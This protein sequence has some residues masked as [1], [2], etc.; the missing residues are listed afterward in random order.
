MRFMMMVKKAGVVVDLSGWQPSSR[1]F[2]VKFPGGKRS[3]VD[4]PFSESKELIAGYG[5]RFQL[6]TTT[7]KARSKFGSLPGATAV[8]RNQQTR[9]ASCA[10]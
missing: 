2:R 1:G 7:A 4:G 10:F 8:L 9:R 3:I 6:R 5:G